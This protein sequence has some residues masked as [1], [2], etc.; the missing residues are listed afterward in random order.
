MLTQEKMNLLRPIEDH[1]KFIHRVTE[2]LYVSPT[3]KLLKIELEYK[4]SLVD[5][6]KEVK[7]ECYELLENGEVDTNKISIPLSDLKMIASIKSKD[8]HEIFYV[9][10]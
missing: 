3:E 4:Q 10:N 5:I 8:S 7:I 1:G 9:E 2:K 6:P